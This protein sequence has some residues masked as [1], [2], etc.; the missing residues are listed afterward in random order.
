[1]E[2]FDPIERRRLLDDVIGYRRQLNRSFE[3]V[4][5]VGGLASCADAYLTT[6]VYCLLVGYDEPAK[7]LLA[8]ARSEAQMSY[9]LCRHYLNGE[10][11]WAEVDMAMRK[12]LKHNVN[13]WLTDGH[14]L[15]AAEWMKI[16]HW[17]GEETP[18][19]ARTV[20]L[21]CY[22]YL[23]A[24]PPDSSITRAGES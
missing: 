11:D 19:S 5:E 15:R 2:V 23:A 18:L 3:R 17:S 4:R 6:A 12:F 8:R 7:A 21:A 24:S 9:V 13:T 16:A 22:D 20:V 10:Y 14:Y 1:M